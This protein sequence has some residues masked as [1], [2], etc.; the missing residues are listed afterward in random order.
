RCRAA[1]PPASRPRT[2][3]RGRGAFSTGAASRSSRRAGLVRVQR[4]A[5]LRGEAVDDVLHRRQGAV[6]GAGDLREGAVV[7]G[8]E[9]A[10]D[11][12]PFALGKVVQDGGDLFPQGRLDLLLG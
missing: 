1:C 4:V 12:L 3:P 10:L 2:V 8:V 6:T 5:E 11:D 7:L 9:V